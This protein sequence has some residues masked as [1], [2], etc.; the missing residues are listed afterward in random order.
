[1][2]QRRRPLGFWHLSLYAVALGFSIRWIPYAAAA[3]PA[4][5]PLWLLA[6]IGFL[7]P[8]AAA[9][10]ELVGRFPGEGGLYGWARE[11][12]GP[13]AGFIAGW[14]YWTCNLPFFSGLLYFIL[15]SLAA[16]FGPAA[17]RAVAD[18]WVLAALASGM[19]VLV[20]LLHLAGLGTGKWLT[21]FGSI[22]V[23]LLTVTLLALGLTLALRSGPA[24]DF[25]HVSYA[26]PLDANGAALWAIMVFAY[27]GP[28]ALAFL[29]GDVDGGVRQILRVLAVVGAAVF[30]AYTAAS[31]AMMAIV[32]P[33]EAS[34]LAGLPEAFA[35]GFA[36]LGQPGL[37][38]LPSLLLGVAMLGS[39]SAWF[40]VAARLPFAIGVD[41]YFPPGFAR[42]NPRTGAPTIAIVVQAAAVVALVVLGQAG[43]SVKAAYDFLVSMSVISYTLPFV[44]LFLSYF[45]VRGAAEAGVWTAPG[46]DRGRRILALVGLA[47]TASAIACTLVPSPD[48]TDK[49]WAVAK[50]VIASVVLIAI[51]ALIYARAVNKAQGRSAYAPPGPT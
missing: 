2:S 41:R 39:Y 14:L 47:V 51:G 40:G 27:G 6:L 15:T 7:V 11:M 18:P 13:F 22:A 8:L 48:A 26:P 43:T 12:L 21:S 31:L 3:G 28:E 19:A 45:R 46:G 36:R 24:S 20:G 1:M 37:A 38:F 29:R 4:S 23:G 35:A 30:I 50:L 49:A 25:A 9:T 5:L 44:F 32:R 42:R 17:T 33:V 10:A 16:G 34:R